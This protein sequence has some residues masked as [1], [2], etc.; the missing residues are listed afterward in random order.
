MQQRA[1]A[2]QVIGDE[3]YKTS[4]TGPLL[5]CLSRNKGKELLAQT[6][7]GVCRGHIDSRALAAKLFK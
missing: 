4:L 5:R 7:S 1:K 3:L 6:H 2:Y